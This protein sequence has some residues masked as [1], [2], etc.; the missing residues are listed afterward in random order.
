MV[1]YLDIESKKSNVPIADGALKLSTTS[2]KIFIVSI[3]LVILLFCISVKSSSFILSKIVFFIKFLP[4]FFINNI[5]SS[6][7]FFNKVKSLTLTPSI[8]L[9][10]LK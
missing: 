1:L 2:V 3:M 9:N 8:F 5:T 7:F 10:L 4:K 6:I